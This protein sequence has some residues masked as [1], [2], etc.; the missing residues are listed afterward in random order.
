MADGRGTA[1]PTGLAPATAGVTSRCRVDFGFGGRRR[2]AVEESNPRPLIWR[3]RCC[4]YTNGLRIAKVRAAGIEPAPPVWKTG[5]RPLHCARGGGPRDGLLHPARLSKG[6]SRRR[7]PAPRPSRLPPRPRQ[8]K[9]PAFFRARGCQ[10][11]LSLSSWSRPALDG[12]PC[13]PVEAITASLESRRK[14]DHGQPRI[15]LRFMAK[16]RPPSWLALGEGPVHG[17]DLLPHSHKHAFP[18]KV[19]RFSS[20]GRRKLHV[21]LQGDVRIG[22]A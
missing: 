4:H 8:T 9:N 1:P 5:M 15:P 7:I 6:T 12:R 10:A 19:R 16:V 20:I 11:S 17:T 18:R 3:Q 21:G 13:G 14:T 2:Q 22:P